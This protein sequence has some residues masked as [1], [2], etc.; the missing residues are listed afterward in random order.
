MYR[1]C[2]GGKEEEGK[3][4]SSSDVRANGK[5]GEELGAE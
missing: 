3:G 5:G 4:N 2:G 1:P